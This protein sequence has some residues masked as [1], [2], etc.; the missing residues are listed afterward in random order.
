[1]KLKTNNFF[2][3]GQRKEIRNLKNKDQIREY[4]I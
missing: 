4:N 3:K 2:A 1:M